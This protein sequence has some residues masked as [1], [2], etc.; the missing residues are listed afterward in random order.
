MSTA[1]PLLR[2]LFRRFSRADDGVTAV[3]FA[4]V[5]PIFF[6]LLIGI[7]ETA[8]FMM[9][10]QMIE[11]ATIDSSRLILTG[12]AQDEGFDAS[13]FKNEVC[14]R[15]PSMIDC[16]GNVWTDVRTL[17][18]FDESVAIPTDDDGNF[19][20][21]KLIYSA[22]GPDDIV[23]VRLYYKWT[24]VIAEAARNVG[25]DL[26]NQPDGSTLMVATMVFRNEPYQ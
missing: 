6:A 15:V 20:S 24:G 26:G 3:E 12:Q 11:T 5:G 25:L 9:A 2:R 19:D 10:N 13:R 14:A 17:S 23:M 21:T 4:I 8:F 1:A 18:T 16:S 7:F 22:G